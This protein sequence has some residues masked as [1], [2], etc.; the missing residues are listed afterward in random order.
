MALACDKPPRY[1][2]AQDGFRV[3]GFEPA[4]RALLTQFPDMPATLI[5]E[6]IAWEH[7][8]SSLP[9]R[10]AL[11]RL[12]YRPADP[13]DRTTYMA[14]EIVQCDPWFPAKVVPVAPKVPAGLPI[15]TM[16]AAY[17]GFI[18]A[19][20]LPLRTTGDLV[21]GMWRLLTRLGG[22]P[23]MLVWDNESGI[24]PH[25][26]PRWGPG[27]SRGRWG[28]GSTRSLHVT[29]RP[30]AWSSE[31]TGFWRLRSCRAALSRPRA[32]TTGSS[33]STPAWTT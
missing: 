22:V 7:S 23:K 32:N 15:L 11:L 4:I 1:Q 3:D 2:R 25:R 28:P 5:A 21:A 29:R 20:L 27:R 24:G 13:A 12:L 14:G 26:R 6:R 18:M 33:I 9:A 16:V 10:I 30:R 8:S 31:P 17:S 19:T